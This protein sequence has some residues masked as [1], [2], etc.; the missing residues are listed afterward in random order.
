MISVI[1][2]LLPST[3]LKIMEVFGFTGDAEYGLRTL[4]SAGKWSFDPEKKKPGMKTSEEGIRR[5]IC[6]MALLLHH[7]VIST[8]LPVNGV[9][10]NIAD[11]VLHFNLKRY[12]EGIFFLYFSGRLYSTQTLGDRAIKQFQLAIQAQKEYIQLQH[13]CLWD[14][15]LTF[16]SLAQFKKAY[17][18]FNVL[19]KESN[20][21]KAIYAYAKATT[22]YETDENSR[23]A[24][25]IMRTVP[26]LMQRIAGKSIPLEKSA[27]AVPPLLQLRMLIALRRRF[28]ARKS[29]K[30]IQQNG[31]LVCPGIELAY[32]L[33]VRPYPLFASPNASLLTSSCLSARSASVSRRALRCTKSISA[34]FRG[35]LPP[36]TSARIRSSGATATSFGTTTWVS[37][38]I[39]AYPAGA[40]ASLQPHSASCIS[41]AASSCASSP[42]RNRTLRRGRPSRRSP[43]RRPT[44]KP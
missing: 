22:L 7:L 9:D 27:V 11:K 19:D 37:L 20:W 42:I 34:K 5:Q 39:S 36:C 1:L 25:E 13:I 4:M 44:S 8:Y 41:S 43:S 17:E 28:V 26:D 38:L 16:L 14:M 29:R 32:V 23:Q 18:C 40:E 3:V 30:F 10:I 33:N 2:S 24:N 31:R 35:N 21:S 6:D 12:P 15:A